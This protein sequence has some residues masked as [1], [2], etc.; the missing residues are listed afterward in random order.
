MNYISHLEEDEEESKKA[1]ATMIKW[2]PGETTDAL[3]AVDVKGEIRRYSAIE[4]KQIDAITTE[5][6]ENNRLF[7]LDYSPDGQTFATGG[8]D[9]SVR[10]YDDATMKLKCIM[11]PFYTGKTG[12][13]NRIFAVKYNKSDPNLLCSSGWDS[14]VI[15]HDIRKKGPVCGMLGTYV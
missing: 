9:H 7:A 1:I 6:G 5:E 2:R 13:S 4:K 3:I 14:T 15:V 10:I 12:H 8:T 11:D